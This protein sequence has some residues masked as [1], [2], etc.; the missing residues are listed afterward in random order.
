MAE[1]PKIDISKYLTEA[2]QAEREEVSRH[3]HPQRE[4]RPQPEKER[5]PDYFQRQQEREGRSEWSGGSMGGGTWA[6]R[7][8]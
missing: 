5:S 6:G 2:R 8:R 1:D 3:M 7:S 4:T